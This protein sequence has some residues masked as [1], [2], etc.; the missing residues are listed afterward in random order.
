MMVFGDG[1]WGMIRS[2]EVMKV[3]GIMMRLVVL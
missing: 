1:L 2:D 3:G